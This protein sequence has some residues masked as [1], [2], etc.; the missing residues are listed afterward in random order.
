MN[1]MKR[2]LELIK[3]RGLFFAST[4]ILDS[5]LYRVFSVRILK[6]S[7][8]S[9]SRDIFKNRKLKESPDGYFYVYPM[10]T[11]AELTTYYSN[12]YWGPSSEKQY[13]VSIR[14]LIHY[15]LLRKFI[16]EFFLEKNKVVANFGADT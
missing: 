3:E 1:K 11:E 4:V 9:I 5:I 8:G 12:T 10:P 2:L 14:D 13:K 7:N 16:P 6:V 15:H